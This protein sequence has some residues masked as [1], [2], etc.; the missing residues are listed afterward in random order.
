MSA[1]F[2]ILIDLIVSAFLLDA[3]NNLK[4]SQSAL[5]AAE[6]NYSTSTDKFLESTAKFHDIQNQLDKLNAQ[7]ATFVR[8]LKNPPVQAC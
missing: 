3:A 7:K 6:E 8:A 2:L 1:L 5:K 4:I